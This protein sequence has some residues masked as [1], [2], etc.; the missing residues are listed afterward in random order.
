[1]YSDDTW[2]R[3]FK[4]AGRTDVLDDE[5][6]NTP[7]LRQRNRDLLFSIVAEITPEKTT[8]E[9]LDLVRAADIPATQM[10]DLDDLLKD[11][12][13]RAV[14]FFKER[15]HP[16]EGRY[17]EMRPAVKFSARPDPAL[18]LPPHIGEHN[19]EISAELGFSQ[20]AKHKEERS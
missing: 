13:L 15:D 11:P 4:L 7:R 17:V 19:A 1:L 20:G 3:F 16:T 5:R 8:K 9:W 10:N 6:L 12:Q 2:L 18:G 14:N